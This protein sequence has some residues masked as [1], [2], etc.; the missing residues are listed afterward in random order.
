[1]KLKSIFALVLCVGLASVGLSQDA[2]FIKGDVNI[3]YNTRSKVDSAGVPEKGVAD[4]YTLD[5]NVSNSSAFRGTIS[6][7]PY[8]A[9]GAFSSNQAGSLIYALETDVINP[10]N[11]SQKKNVGKIFG[12]VPVNENNVYDYSSGGV[13]N[14][15]FGMGQGRGFE[16]KY[17][18]L[19]LGKPPVRKTG[20]FES[21]K[22]DALKLVNGKGASIQITKY[23]KMEF[24]NL[25][26]ASGPVQFYP[27]SV[28]SG[29]MI[30]DYGR[31]AWHFQS[32]TVTY[33]NPEDGKRVQDNITGNI[34]WN[35]D[36]YDFDVRVNEPVATEASM[37]AAASKEEDFFAVDNS[38]PALTGVMKY[39]DTQSGGKVIASSV[40]VDLTGNKLAKQQT[41]YLAKL[42]FL[43][44][45]VP[46][47]A[48]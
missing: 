36:Q 34:R 22:Q 33:T 32:V 26:L 21:V 20:F 30:Y 44:S 16:S 39:K 23:D 4:I 10:K 27:D 14:N 29:V 25:T 28:V 5:L 48:E 46:I 38:N 18:G 35:K 9:G 43:V 8:I 19:A 2:T 47:N 11:P 1:M 7:V 45:I 3:R 31:S 17:N 24:Q 40:V 41:M 12:S 13:K 42:I 6:Q 15:T 37:F